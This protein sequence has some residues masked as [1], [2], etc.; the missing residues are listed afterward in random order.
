MVKNPGLIPNMKSIQ[1]G[2]IGKRQK[3]I[4][5]ILQGCWRSCADLTEVE[6][7]EQSQ[8]RTKPFV[9][10]AIIAN[11][12]SFAHIH[13]AEKLGIPVHL[14]FTYEETVDKSDARYR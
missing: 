6:K 10:H 9:A 4:Y 8:S 14:M 11:P 2:D 1:A 12:P 5:Q 3:G 13:C 7:D